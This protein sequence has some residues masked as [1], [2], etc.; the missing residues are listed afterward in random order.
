MFSREEVY[1]CTVNCC[2]EIHLIN[3]ARHKKQWQSSSS[4]RAGQI[5]V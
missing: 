5:G 1:Y 4:A 3:V 2:T